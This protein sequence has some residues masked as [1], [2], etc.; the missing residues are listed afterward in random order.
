VTAGAA[1]LNGSVLN[2]SAPASVRTV[3][4]ADALEW[5]RAHGP[6]VGASV[7]TS[8][9]DVSEVPAL[10]F[11]GWRAWFGQAAE[12]VMGAVPDDGLAIFF[13]SDIRRDGVWVDKGALV[14]G[15]AAAAGMLP[16]FHK[17]VCRLPPGTVTFG[18]A[19]YA[20]LLGFGRR[21]R[22]TLARGSADVLADAGFMPGNKSMGV[23]ACLEA[24]RFV[25]AETSTRTIVDPFCGWGTVLAVANA[26][27]M[28]AVGVDLSVRMCRKARA[29]RL[30][31]GGLR[32]RPP[33]AGAPR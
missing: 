4:R 24:C 28:D 23:N 20:H 22:P 2:G 16:L 11:D 15:A 1:P 31:V 8:L 30:D 33:S 32:A 6:L 7:I 26:L 10:G 13:Q 21:P 14:S 3:H 29:L 9:P 19:S 17:I 12:A 5:L 27:G 18:R 25:K